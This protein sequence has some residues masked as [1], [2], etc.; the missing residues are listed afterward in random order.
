MR[1]ERYIGIDYS[2][3]KS[4]LSRLRGLQ[5]YETDGDGPPE[6]IRPPAKGVKNWSRRE[7]TQFCQE[8]LN[9]NKR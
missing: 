6:K 7:V 4:P 2:G 1:F 8:A 9:Q 5:V 3:A